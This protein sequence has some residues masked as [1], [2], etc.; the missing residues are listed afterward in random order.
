M[1]IRITSSVFFAGWEFEYG[2]Y[3]YN[4]T[5]DKKL[6]HSAVKDCIQIG[7]LAAYR[8]INNKDSFEELR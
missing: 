4:I 2:D 6:Y 7:G 5:E 3:Y 1:Q 8:F